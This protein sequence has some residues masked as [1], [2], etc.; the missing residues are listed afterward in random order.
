MPDYNTPAQYQDACIAMMRSAQ[1]VVVASLDL[2]GWKAM[3]PAMQ[4]PAPK[5]RVQFE[6]VLTSAF[7][8][9]DRDGWFELRRRVP[10]LDESACASITH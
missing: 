5:E 2:A 7:A 10:G 8:F 1:W 4:D 3:Y 9:V 6:H